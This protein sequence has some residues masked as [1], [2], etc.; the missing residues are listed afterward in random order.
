MEHCII[1]LNSTWFLTLLNKMFCVGNGCVPP[2]VLLVLV[3][4][5]LLKDNLALDFVLEVFA[6]VKQ[7]RGV[8]SLVTALKRGQLEGRSVYNNDYS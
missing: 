8:T 6:T 2:S 7:E 3:N 5:H 1:K 4:E